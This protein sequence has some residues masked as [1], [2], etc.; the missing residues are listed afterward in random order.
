M[1]RSSSL[2]PSIEEPKEVDIEEKIFLFD[3]DVPLE[4]MLR[5]LPLV[6]PWSELH[7]SI[8]TLMYDESRL[9]VLLNKDHRLNL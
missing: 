7:N 1:S 4:L 6:D 3:Y 9:D 5:K 8:P 2:Q